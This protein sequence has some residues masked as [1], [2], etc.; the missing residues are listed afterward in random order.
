RWDLW[1]RNDSVGIISIRGTTIQA[2]S[3]AEDFYAA[4]VPAKGS[5]IIDSNFVFIYMLAESEKASVHIGWLTGLAYL[6]ES[7]LTK[8][9]EYHAKGIKDYLIVGHSQGGAI[10]Y[11]L[12][13]YFH[14]TGK[15][16]IPEGTN[17]KTYCSAPPKPGNLFYSYDYDFINRGGWSLRVYNSEDWVPQ[18]PIS[19]QT[20]NDFS[21]INPYSERDSFIVKMNLLDKIIF[22]YLV[23]KIRGT[24]DDSKDLLNDY[25][26]SMV[27]KYSITKFLPNF[28]EPQYTDDAFFYPCGVPVVLMKQEGYDE[29]LA[30]ET[31][32]PL[33]FKNHM[34][35]P[36]YFLLNKIYF[37]K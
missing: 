15:G 6:S 25:F 2:N 28:P 20:L 27:Y 26:G 13:S 31:T 18:T 23:A 29:I 24:L 17:F 36:Y 30:K 9:N 3:W 33:L 14:Y 37:E 11:L 8:I 7:I 35:I 12:N 34:I 1:I 4:M 22:D 5:I 32:I 21:E 16:R 10:A 19:V